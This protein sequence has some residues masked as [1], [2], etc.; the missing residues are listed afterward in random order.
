MRT[1][2]IKIIDP[3]GIHARPASA[4]VSAASKFSSEISFKMN[5]KVANAKSIINLM[6]LGAKQNSIIDIVVNG[7][8]EEIALHTILE[9]L[10][11]ENII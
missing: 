1:E 2:N 4:I 11:K 10:K 7:A 9:L 5:E 3:I 6:A 8:D